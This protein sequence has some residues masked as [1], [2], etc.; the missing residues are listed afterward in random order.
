VSI[1]SPRAGW[2]RTLNTPTGLACLTGVVA[3]VVLAFTTPGIPIVWDEGE[4]LWRAD[5][6]GEWFRLLVGGTGWHG[7]LRM[8]APDV[9]HEY[10]H[11]VTWDEG[12]PGWGA[13]PVAMATALFGTVLHPLTAARMGSVAVFS[14][15]CAGVAYRLRKSHGLVASVVAVAALL[16]LP[17]LFAEAHL[18]TLD[19]QLTAW[20]LLTWAAASSTTVGAGP[21]VGIGV[22]AGLTTAT[23]FPGGLV[24]PPLIASRLLNA[25]RTGRLA[26]LAMVPVG[27]VT[28]YAANPPFWRHPISTASTYVQLNLHRTLNVPMVFFGTT[29]DLH[30]P[31]PWFNTVAWLLI[32]TPVPLL[33]LGAFGVYRAVR[34]RD[35]VGIGLTLHWGTMMVA[36]ALPGA[37]PHD[38]IRLFLPAFGFWCLLAGTGAQQLWTRAGR[39]SRVRFARWAIVVGLAGGAVNVWR[40]YPQT[41]SH[42]NLL[43]GGVSG[44]TA[45]GMEPT[46]WWDSLDRETLAWLNE[47]TAVGERVAFSSTANISMIRSWGQLIPEQADRRGVFKWYVFQN[48]TSFLAD[49]DR[50]LMRTRQPAFV[51]YPGHHQT[52]H[53]PRDLDVPLLFI[54]SYEQYHAA[55][56]EATVR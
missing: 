5:R 40:Y 2:A 25:G 1:P 30:R 39:P 55:L 8:L 48:R 13:V 50:L 22:L 26:L 7:R 38:G 16:T 4:Y 29:Y 21:A 9:I 28:F 11:F 10:W 49:S 41:L 42:Y 12:H 52:G 35:A 19:G 27:V 47:H 43:V 54:Y 37:P 44:A 15:A 14:A 20:W 56:D 24:W 6:V 31:L 34:Q 18:A 36:R 23:K 46:Y 17:R 32:V 45:L 53:V 51:K 3:I 33:A